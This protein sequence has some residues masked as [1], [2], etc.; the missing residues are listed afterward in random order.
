VIADRAE[1]TG[2][3]AALGLHVAIIAALSLSLANVDKE[4]EPPAMDVELVDDVALDS[5]APQSVPTRLRPA[6]F[7]SP[8][9]RMTLP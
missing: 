2:A 1:R 8:I 6:R 3:V 7:N 5:A 9:T 4:P